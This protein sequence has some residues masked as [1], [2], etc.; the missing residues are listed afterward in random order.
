MERKP[1]SP[2]TK[3]LLIAVI[4]VAA[5]A[6]C[7]SHQTS[8]SV[9]DDANAGDLVD[10]E[11]C[12]YKSNKKSYAADCGALVVPE[13][14]SDP[15]SRLI[16]LP[17]I[18]IR[19]LSESPAEPIF[20]LAGGPGESNMT[21]PGLKGLIQNHDIVMVGYRGVDGL[22]V[23]DC[24]EMARA[25]KGSG[26]DLLSEASLSHFGEATIKCAERLQAE[27]VDLDGYSIP[28]VVED[29]EAARAALGYE[30]V[31]LLSGSYGT[32]VAMIYSWMYPDSLHRSAMVAVNP[33]GHFVW[34]PEVIDSLI[35]YDAA[36]CAND[37]LCSSRTND[38]AES[39][40][41]VTENFPIRW[42]MIPI[43]SGKVE[44]VTHFMLFHRG[45]AATVFD[46]YLSAENGDPSGLALMSLAYDFM[47]PSLITWGD[48]IA[49]GSID[50]SPTRDW[51]TDMN[52]PNSILGSPTSF[53][54]GGAAQL[55]GGWPV[56]PMAEEFHT[57]QPSDVETLLISGSVDYSTPA[58]FA[59]EEL[60][61]ALENGEQVILSEFG[62][63]N[64][65]WSFQPEA[66][67]HLLVT[68]YDTGEVDDSLFTYQPWDYNV[69]LGFP[70]IAKIALGSIGILILSVVGGIWFFLKRFFKNRNKK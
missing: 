53:L 4:L 57:V 27:R 31:N 8:I 6:G 64:D 30:R 28:E 22:V 58:Q 23:L 68:F 47:I 33:P 7:V 66:T 67:K 45:T 50:Y 65:V 70:A 36:L 17:V 51:I 37:P 49:K 3:M 1:F 18:R 52:P 59:A 29:M 19:A 16:A 62:H 54:V 2:K 12:T 13:N 55:K 11:D 26:N 24:P 44:F 9:P 40:R 20:W 38:L 32:R 25:A 41:N 39:M 35:E 10:F 14:R 60:H 5:L 56:A 34:E 61:P 15:I 63:F 21:F 46:S 48:W 43:D 42:L 69:G